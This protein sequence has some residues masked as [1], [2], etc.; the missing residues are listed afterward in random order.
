MIDPVA[1]PPHLDD[2]P[3]HWSDS[4]YETSPRNRRR[5]SGRSSVTAGEERVDLR[6]REGARGLS[7]VVPHAGQKCPLETLRCYR[8]LTH[9]WERGSVVASPGWWPSADNPS[10]DS[11]TLVPLDLKTSDRT[12]SFCGQWP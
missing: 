4:L 5:Q 3:S 12:L 8:I 9:T 1:K 6:H 7:G 10:S 2:S 11:F